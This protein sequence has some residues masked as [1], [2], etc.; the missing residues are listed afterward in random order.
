LR[1][2]EAFERAF[3]ERVE[4]D[5]LAAALRHFAQ[6]RHHPRMVGAGIVADRQDQVGVV[7]ILEADGALADTDRLRES[8]RSRLVAHVRAIG[9]VIGPVQPHE[10]LEQEGS[11]VR[12]ASRGVEFRLVRVRHGGKASANFAH[13]LVPAHDFVVI[14]GGIIA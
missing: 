2:F 10:Q 6:G 9:E 5:D 3:L 11:F 7:E 12:A 14:G 8:N 13:R 4:D 1:R